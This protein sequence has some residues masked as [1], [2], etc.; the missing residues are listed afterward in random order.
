[1][2]T[3]AIAKIAGNIAGDTNSSIDGTY[4]LL[5]QLSLKAK[6]SPLISFF[7]SGKVKPYLILE[8]LLGR[9]S[10]VELC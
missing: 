2:G 5:N 4:T 6:I 10:S 3:E 8:G 9:V 7:D 1:M